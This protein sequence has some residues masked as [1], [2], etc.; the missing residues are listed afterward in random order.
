MTTI[1]SS[2]FKKPTDARIVLGKIQTL[3]ATP[4]VFPLLTLSA[5][6]EMPRGPSNRMLMYLFSVYLL[7]L[8]KGF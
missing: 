8:V 5:S 4:R 1:E 2:S 3:Q 7:S 6:G